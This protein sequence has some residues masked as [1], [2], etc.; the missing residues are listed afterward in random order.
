MVCRIRS[1]TRTAREPVGGL[2][3]Q[4]ARRTGLGG[5]LSRRSLSSLEVRPSVAGV[6]AETLVLEDADD[7]P[8]LLRC[9]VLAVF[10]LGLE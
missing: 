9:E 7:S 10:K 6:G 2:R 3:E 1:V 5:S 8:T 4:H